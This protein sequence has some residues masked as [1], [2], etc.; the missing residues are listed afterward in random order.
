MLRVVF[1]R[2]SCRF[3]DVFCDNNCSVLINCFILFIYVIH[4]TST[5][6]PKSKAAMTLAGKLQDLYNAVRDYTDSHGRTLSTPY[7]KMPPKSVSLYVLT[8]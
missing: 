1:L 6:R 8:C 5:G 3:N 7:M 4:R 2:Q